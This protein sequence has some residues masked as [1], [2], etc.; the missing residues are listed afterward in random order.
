M[1][2]RK[3]LTIN[4]VCFIFFISHKASLAFLIELEDHPTKLY[5]PQL[6]AR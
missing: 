2:G 6:I 5:D 3:E 4:F 1:L